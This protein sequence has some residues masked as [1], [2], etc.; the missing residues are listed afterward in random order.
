MLRHEVEA[1]VRQRSAQCAQ[2]AAGARARAQGGLN[3]F[4]CAIMPWLQPQGGRG[5]AP[6]CGVDKGVQ[7][8]MDDVGKAFQARLSSC[9]ISFHCRFLSLTILPAL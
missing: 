7:Q 5:A 8:G 3:P 9:V 4:L 1:M 6:L 2:L